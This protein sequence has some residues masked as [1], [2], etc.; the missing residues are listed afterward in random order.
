MLQ[1][2]MDKAFWT[3]RWNERR[4]GFHEGHANH[5]LEAYATRLAGDGGAGTPGVLVPLAG[6]ADDMRWLAA[7][8]HAVVGVEFVESAAREFFR[9]SSIEPRERTV[10]PFVALSCGGVEVFVG[11]FFDATSELLGTF[12]AAYDRAALVAVEP[13]RRAEYV[14]RLASLMEP[15]GR[16]LL[17][18]FEYPPS[19]AMTGPPFSV[20][21][22]EVRSLF[23]ARFGLEL[24][25]DRDAVAD[26]GRYKARGVTSMREAA[27]L[28][29]RR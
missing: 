5:Y 3:A 9:E 23:D 29:T 13:Q 10:G 27:Y 25:D 12:T 20:S 4:I 11:D 18:T 16:V 6:K 28:L 26:A 8:G 22:D 14:E 7:R 15:G 24:L 21:A 17:V 19:P 2:V 1:R